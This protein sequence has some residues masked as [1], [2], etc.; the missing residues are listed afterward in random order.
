MYSLGSVALT[1]ISLIEQLRLCKVE[2]HMKLNNLYK[3]CFS[4]NGR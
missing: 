1:C 4:R 3:I 2:R